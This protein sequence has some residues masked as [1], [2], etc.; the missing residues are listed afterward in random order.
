MIRALFYLV[1][2]SNELVARM[3]RWFEP[4][5]PRRAKILLRNGC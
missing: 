1:V 5:N 4:G 3:V 2:S